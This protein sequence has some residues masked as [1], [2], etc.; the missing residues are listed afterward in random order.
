MEKG[1]NVEQILYEQ[2]NQLR[3]LSRSEAKNEPELV[4]NIS[5]A[6]VE[7]AKLFNLYPTTQGF[8]ELL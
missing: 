4:V 5:L 1:K 2:L 3:E 8:D 6:M 7:I